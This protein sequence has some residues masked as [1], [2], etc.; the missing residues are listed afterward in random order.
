MVKIF[1]LAIMAIFAGRVCFAVCA[2]FLPP[3]LRAEE[4]IL[5][6]E[7]LKKRGSDASVPII[8]DT[9]E[10]VNFSFHVGPLSL[11]P[12]PPAG[13]RESEERSSEQGEGHPKLKK[14]YRSKSLS[15]RVAFLK[16]SARIH[17][18]SPGRLTQT[19]NHAFKL[20]PETA[21]TSCAGVV[22]FPL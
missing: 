2:Q 22:D 19:Y 8:P 4:T 5:I 6:G 13:E 14:L 12:S 3:I 15:V 16:L 10:E 18:L 20:V 21:L 11:D 17:D 7:C 9:S 1:I